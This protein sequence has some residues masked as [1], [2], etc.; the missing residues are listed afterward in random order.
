M[1]TV[2]SFDCGRQLIWFAAKEEVQQD[3]KAKARWRRIKSILFSCV[4]AAPQIVEGWGRS[5]WW[6]CNL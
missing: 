4:G 3:F 1:V 6:A 5:N 2:A